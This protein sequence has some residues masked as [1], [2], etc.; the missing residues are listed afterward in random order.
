MNE[1]KKTKRNDYLL[2]NKFHTSLLA[3]L[4]FETVYRSSLRLNDKFFFI[5]NS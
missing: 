4:L 5:L 1:Y 3:N 2:I